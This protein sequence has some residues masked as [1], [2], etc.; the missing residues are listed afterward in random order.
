MYRI[1]SNGPNGMN[2]TATAYPDTALQQARIA[3]EEGRTEVWIADDQGK[4]FTVEAF[5]KG[6]GAGGGT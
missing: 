2:Q 5:A 6:P 3:I 1:T 4:L